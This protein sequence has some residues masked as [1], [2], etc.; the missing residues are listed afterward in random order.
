MSYKLPVEAR[1]Q[2][3][4]YCSSIHIYNNLPDDLAQLVSSMKHFLIQLKKNI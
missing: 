4:V 1:Y 3:S 2:K